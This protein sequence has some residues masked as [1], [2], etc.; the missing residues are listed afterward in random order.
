M[1]YSV[2]AMLGETLLSF[3]LG[4]CT[5]DVGLLHAFAKRVVFRRCSCEWP[6]SQLGQRLHDASAH[7]SAQVLILMSEDG[8]VKVD[9]KQLPQIPQDKI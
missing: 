8:S 9:N 5:L 3:K 2:E 6:G 1:H 4:L 7:V